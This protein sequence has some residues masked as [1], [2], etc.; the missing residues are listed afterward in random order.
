MTESR[1]LFSQNPPS[2]MF[3]RVWPINE[4]ILTLACVGSLGVCFEV[5]GEGV[6][7]GGE[8]VKLPHPTV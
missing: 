5:R 2:Q 7:G 8:V 6:G 3:E 4:F 1:G